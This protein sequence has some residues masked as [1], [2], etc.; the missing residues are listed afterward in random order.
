MNVFRVLQDPATAEDLAHQVR[1]TPY[2]REELLN[3]VDD[4]EL[5]PV[6]RARRTL[7]R[8]HMGASPGNGPQKSL[9]TS[10][11]NR[12]HAWSWARWP[13]DV[14]TWSRRLQGVVI[15]NRDWREVVAEQPADALIYA[16]PPYLA[17]TRTGTTEYTHELD[18]ADDHR[19]LAGALRDRVA[20][21]SGYGSPEYEKLYEGWRVT[22]CRSASYGG[23]GRPAGTSR[24]EYVWISPRAQVPDL[25]G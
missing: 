23:A 11:G 13:D 16:D 15:E 14:P 19:A 12:R 7:I 10:L 3:A 20:V 4:L 6:E 8:C 1:L 5:A 25:F 18:E 9:R 17:E 2:A 22:S 24:R 21:V